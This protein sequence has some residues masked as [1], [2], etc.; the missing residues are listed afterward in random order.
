LVPLGESVEQR[1]R[2]WRFRASCCRGGMDMD[3]E[4][5][6]WGKYPSFPGSLRHRF[7]DWH[8]RPEPIPF[9]PRDEL[10][11]VAAPVHDE[12][13][14]CGPSGPWKVLEAV[15]AYGPFTGAVGDV[16]RAR[17]DLV[18][19]L[20]K[21]DGRGSSLVEPSSFLTIA[22]LLHLEP[23]E[24][25]ARYCR[26]TQDPWRPCPRSCPAGPPPTPRGHWQVAVA[27]A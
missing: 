9:G 10:L 3:G 24:C 2:E 27:S 17:R 6:R 21:P 4:A 13:R 14:L 18:A 1:V 23:R 7:D 15:A 12:H 8:Q 19:V 16:A 11:T 26:P 20:I 5:A 22:S 25:A